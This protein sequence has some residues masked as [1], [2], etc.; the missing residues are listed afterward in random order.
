MEV[1]SKTLLE[2]QKQHLLLIVGEFCPVKFFG[3]NC[4]RELLRDCRASTVTHLF[5]PS[6]KHRL[7]TT[8]CSVLQCC[9]VLAEVATLASIAQ[10]L[11]GVLLPMTHALRSILHDQI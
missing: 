2:R 7:R 3:M 5:L 4:S 8:R 6:N 9:R 10:L 11:H 1:C